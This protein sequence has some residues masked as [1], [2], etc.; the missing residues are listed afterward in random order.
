MVRIGRCTSCG[1]FLHEIWRERENCPNCGGSID[2]MEVKIG[3][4]VYLPRAL[5]MVGLIML[6]IGMILLIAAPAGKNGGDGSLTPTLI[7]VLVAVFFFIL[8]LISQLLIVRKAIEK[9][10]S[11]QVKE[12]RLK[13]N[14]DDPPRKGKVG[15]KL[16]K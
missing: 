13:S 14:R 10:A 12:R 4:V 15:K 6:V 16:I 8:S 7:L 1:A 3:P 5:N 2:H 11:S 9:K